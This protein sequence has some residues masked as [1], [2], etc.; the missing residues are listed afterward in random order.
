MESGFLRACTR[1]HLVKP[2]Y[3]RS[4]REGWFPLPPPLLPSLSRPPVDGCHRVETRGRSRG[5]PASSYFTRDVIQPTM[6]FTVPWN[7]IGIRLDP[8]A[9]DTRVHTR[10]TP[11]EIRGKKKKRFLIG[12]L[13][14]VT[15]RTIGFDDSASRCLDL[16]F[17]V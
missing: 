11:R 13:D 15:S 1:T 14:F 2:G 8:S 4:L 6:N 5:Q 9:T 16:L 7:L 3:E 12:K 10:E 17:P